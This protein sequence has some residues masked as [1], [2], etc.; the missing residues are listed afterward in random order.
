MPSLSNAFAQGASA[1][2]LRLQ[3]LRKKLHARTVMM[4]SPTMTMLMYMTT[5]TM[6]TMITLA[7]TEQQQLLRKN[8]DDGKPNVIVTKMTM[9]IVMAMTMTLVKMT[10]I[11]ILR[12]N[13]L[14][15]S[16]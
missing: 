5:M 16:S 11:T 6:I 8:S 2:D 12:R 9:L 10:M 15:F 7:E 14:S 13:R 3:L 1:D 4:A